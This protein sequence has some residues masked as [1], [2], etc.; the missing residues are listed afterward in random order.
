MID[1]T[2]IHQ[3]HQEDKSMKI[4]HDKEIVPEKVQDETQD[5]IFAQNETEC[6]DKAPTTE[7]LGE[8]E[9]INKRSLRSMTKSGSSAKKDYCTSAGFDPRMHIRQLDANFAAQDVFYPSLLGDYYTNSPQF[10]QFAYSPMH[11][12]GD[13]DLPNTIEEAWNSYNS[14]NWEEAIQMELDIFREK[15]I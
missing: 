9:S 15:N 1:N 5:E 7:D 13:E 10:Y 4:S 3:N 8:M 2:I 11:K 14:E 12:N 6:L